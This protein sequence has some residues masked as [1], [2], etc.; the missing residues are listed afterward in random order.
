MKGYGAL[1]DYPNS[2]RCLDFS[3]DDIA[4]GRDRLVDALFAWGDAG[5][6]AER[7]DAHFAVGADHVCLHVIVERPDLEASALRPA[8]RELAAALL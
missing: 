6:I 5:Q 8:W 2:W 4:T 3:K 7:S 1:A